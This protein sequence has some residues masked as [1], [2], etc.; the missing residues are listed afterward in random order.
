[1]AQFEMGI[2]GQFSGKV[3][4]IIG[5]TWKGKPY[6]KR[7]NPTRTEKISDKEK[8]NRVKFTK[9]QL[10]LKPI[11]KFVRVGFKGY[12]PTWEGFVAAKSHLM[13]NAME[14]TGAAAIINPAKVKVSFGD[15]SLSPNIAV[16]LVENNK[17][18]FTW[19]TGPVDQGTSRDQVMLLAYDIE[20]ALR[21]S[22]TY[23]A[24]RSDG[25]D[26]IQVA[27]GYTYHI[28]IAFNAHDRS[29]QSDSVYLGTITV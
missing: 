14:G 18:Q 20:K 10:W 22:T 8:G 2:L 17:L 4:S 1:M 11:I 29:R 7:A 19:D 21:I 24:F 26:I 6:I 16:S 9:A 12:T 5:S 13:K 25:S 3:G 15:L 27:P 28:Y 23:G